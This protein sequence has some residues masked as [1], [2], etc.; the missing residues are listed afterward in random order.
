MTTNFQINGTDLNDYFL[1]DA[2]NYGSSASRNVYNT[3][4]NSSSS[5]IDTKRFVLNDP[6]VSK[7]DIGM[8]WS[9]SN[10]VSAD[11]AVT[12]MNELGNR[13][14]AAAWGGGIYYSMNYGVDF[15]K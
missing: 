15:K 7:N 11:W 5:D 2:K 10:S 3:G 12:A 9:A 4:L 14:V 6:T 13:A 1:S 8:T